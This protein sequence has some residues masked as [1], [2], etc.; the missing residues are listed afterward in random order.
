MVPLFRSAFRVGDPVIPRAVG[1][2]SLGEVHLFI[3]SMVLF[4]SDGSSRDQL[5][6]HFHC[7]HAYLASKLAAPPLP[8]ASPKQMDGSCTLDRQLPLHP[9]TPSQRFNLRHGTLDI[10]PPLRSSHW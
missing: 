2:L 3:E 8:V 4:T 6:I 7:Q 5:S 9:S 1:Q 10:W